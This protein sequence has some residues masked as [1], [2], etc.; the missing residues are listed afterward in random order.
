M[1]LPQGL[2]DLKRVVREADLKVAG[3]V[4]DLDAGLIAKPTAKGSS[5][6]A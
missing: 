3:A 4:L 1:L 6:P 2:K 5:M